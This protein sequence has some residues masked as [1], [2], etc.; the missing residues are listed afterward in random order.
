MAH[1]NLRKFVITEALSWLGAKSA[2]FVC[3]A[4]SP[5][6]ARDKSNMDVTD[7]S[8]KLKAGKARKQPE[9]PKYMLEMSASRWIP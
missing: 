2:C 1:R 3:S 9:P 8:Q 7:R 4:I 5:I 6:N